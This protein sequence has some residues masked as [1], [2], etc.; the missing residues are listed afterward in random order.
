MQNIIEYLSQNDPNRPN[1]A[2]MGARQNL[3]REVCLGDGA[4]PLNE[5]ESEAVAQIQS[6]Y[7]NE[8]W[9]KAIMPVLRYKYPH[10][11]NLDEF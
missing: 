8:N 10:V 2:E 3:V 7:Y 11:A 9:H 5:E 1:F 4:E 6:K